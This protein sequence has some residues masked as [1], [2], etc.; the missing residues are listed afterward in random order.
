M[1]PLLAVLSLIAFT[2]PALDKQSGPSCGVIHIPAGAITNRE[3]M[4]LAEKEGRMQ[5]ADIPDPGLRAFSRGI[6]DGSNAAAFY[7]RVSNTPE[8]QEDE[9]LQIIDEDVLFGEA[10]ACR[11]Q[12]CHLV[13]IRPLTQIALHWLV[14]MQRDFQDLADIRPKKPDVDKFISDMR[15]ADEMPDSG[16]SK[17][18][19]LYCRLEPDGK[20]KDLRDSVV[21]CRDSHH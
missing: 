15:T 8:V 19:V 17:L 12:S 1:K 20:Y 11:G 21:L 13:F 14:R 7:N 2:P 16:W 9:T 10:L 6:D 18:T 4:S 5:V 3:S